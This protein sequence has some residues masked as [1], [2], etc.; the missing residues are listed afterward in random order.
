MSGQVKAGTENGPDS[1]P[2]SGNHPAR[3]VASYFLAVAGLR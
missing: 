3:F 2:S 1:F